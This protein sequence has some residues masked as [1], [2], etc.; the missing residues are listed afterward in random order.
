MPLPCKN[1]PLLLCSNSPA[2]PAGR[3]NRAI[4]P[5][6]SGS[7]A[8]RHD[9][10]KYIKKSA[11]QSVFSPSLPPSATNA[12]EHKAHPIQ[13][14]YDA[15][16]L[17]HEDSSGNLQFPSQNHAAAPLILPVYPVPAFQPSGSIRLPH[18]NCVY[19]N[20]APFHRTLFYVQ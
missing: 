20:P 2:V 6:Q 5:K 1:F 8:N 18:W 11:E 9:A 16:C 4:F 12:D 13:R 14:D 15:C 7:P 17:L 3:L 19:P 10:R